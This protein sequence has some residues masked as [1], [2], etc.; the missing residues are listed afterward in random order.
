M[1]KNLISLKQSAAQLNEL[2]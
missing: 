1:A 2:L